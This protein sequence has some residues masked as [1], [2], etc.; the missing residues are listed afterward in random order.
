MNATQTQTVCIIIRGYNLFK[1]KVHCTYIFAF[2]IC[3]IVLL[4]YSK[5][6]VK[7]SF[8]KVVAILRYLRNGAVISTM[9]E[10]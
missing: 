8:Q 5:T 7:I 1:G 2:W 6:V 10:E 3:F 9:Q 4:R